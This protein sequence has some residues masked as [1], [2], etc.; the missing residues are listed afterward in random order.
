MEIC[1]T[2]L[3]TGES[4]RALEA[5]KEKA[6]CT[7]TVLRFERLQSPLVMG[8]GALPSFRIRIRS[9]QGWTHFFRGGGAA[10]GI[11]LCIRRMSEYSMR[12]S[13]LSMLYLPS[14]AQ[15]WYWNYLLYSIFR[16]CL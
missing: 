4:D 11:I 15:W 5:L 3:I 12:F 14:M 6:D 10:L 8:L 9:Q 2:F 7:N 1:N 13:R 16:A